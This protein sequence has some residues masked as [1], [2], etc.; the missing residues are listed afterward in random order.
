[1]NH[2]LMLLPPAQVSQIPIYIVRSNHLALVDRLTGGGGGLLLVPD[3]DP[4]AL[5]A[6]IAE[7]GGV[8]DRSRS[9]SRPPLYSSSS[10]SPASCPRTSLPHP[11][12]EA[13][14]IISLLPCLSLAASLDSCKLLFLDLRVFLIGSSRLTEL[15]TAVATRLGGAGGGRRLCFEAADEAEEG[16]RGEEERER[17]SS[18]PPPPMPMLPRLRDISSSA[19]RSPSTSSS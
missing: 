10:S 19:D 17:V 12:C 11:G 9:P 4:D 5:V 15:A 1:M 13:L 6:L 14:P 8:S 16:R 7:E 18:P 3:P 2:E